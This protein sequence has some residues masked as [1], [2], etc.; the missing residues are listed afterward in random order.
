MCLHNETNQEFSER[1]HLRSLG[2]VISKAD[3]KEFDMLAK[4]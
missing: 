3:W 2:I 4:K 1:H